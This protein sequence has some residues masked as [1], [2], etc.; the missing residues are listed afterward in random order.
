MFVSLIQIIIQIILVVYLGFYCDE[1]ENKCKK[2]GQKDDNCTH[3]EIW[4]DEF[5][6]SD[7]DII[8]GNCS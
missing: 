5:L 1:E 7:E 4:E 2:M 6:I 8:F 3:D